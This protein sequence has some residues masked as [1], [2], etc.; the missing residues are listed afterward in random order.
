MSTTASRRSSSTLD[1]VRSLLERPL[2]SYQLVLGT[3]GAAARPRPDHG[4][5]RQLGV[6]AARLRQ[7]VRDL[8]APAIFAVLGRHGRWSS[9]CGCRWRVLRQLILPAL[10]GVVAAD[11]PDLHAAGHGRQ[12]QPQLAP[13][14]RAA[15]TCSRRSSPSSRSCCGSPTSTRAATSHLG[16]PRYVITP[17]VPVAGAVARPRRVPEG[18]RHRR[19][20]VRDHRR[21][22]VGRRAAA[23]SRCSRFGA[24]L[25]VLL[26]FFVA[27]AQ[28][29]VDRFMTFLNP[30]ADPGEVGLPGDQ[31][32]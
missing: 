16:T 5:E 1:T 19:R 9:R 12:R 23:A 24:G 11:R 13:A 26:L 30:M 32:A 21:H 7:L 27:T 25:F 3:T 15:S 6:R 8:R 18:P 2:A 20:P 17:M 14:V 10:L 28:H 4:A 22:A 31:G 29:R